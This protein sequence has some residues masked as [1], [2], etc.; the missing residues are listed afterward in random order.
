M[1]DK[2]QFKGYTGLCYYNCV[3]TKN[4]R[5][6]LK[7]EECTNKII[8]YQKVGNKYNIIFNNGKQYTYAGYNVKIIESELKDQKA[9]NCFEYLKDIANAI[10]LTKNGENILLSNYNKIDFI[11]SNS[12]LA[13]FI[14]QK[15]PNNDDKLKQNIVY[16]FGF[17]N[18]Q[19]LA[20]N[21]AL[22]N[23]LSIIQGP[24]GTGKTQTIL[25]II[26]N[27][28]MSG[29][30]V[31]VVSS[32]NSATKNVLDKLKKYDVDFIAAFLGNL[33]NRQEFIKSQSEIPDIS[34]WRIEPELFAELDNKLN[35]DYKELQEKLD[36]QN[37]LALLRQELSNVEL[38]QK[39]FIEYY[40]TLEVK[41]EPKCIRT[42]NSSLKTLD[43][44]FACDNYEEI[45]NDNSLIKFILI[46][47]EYLKL[48]DRKRLTLHNLIRK[49][50]YTLDFLKAQF[51]HKFYELKIEELKTDIK[52]LNNN[53][54]N[55]DFA[56]KMKA[57]SELSAR[58]FKH[59]LNKKYNTLAREP[60]KLEDLKRKANMFIEDY[61]VVLST[62][63]SLK[64]C[65]SNDVMYDYVIIDEASQ[66]DLCTGALAL[67]CARKA[68]VVGDLKQL[69]NVVNK[70]TA[71]LTDNIFRQYQLNEAYRYKNHCLLSSI[72]ELFKNAPKTLLKE[73]YRCHPKIIEFC[74]RKFYN[75]ELIILS[76]VKSDRTPLVLCYTTEGNHARNHYNQRQIDMIV[77][78]IIP[79]Y[80]ICLEDNSLGIVT[81]YRNQT[82]ALQKVF[83]G[84]TVK[85]DTVDKFQGQENKVIIIST[86]D[87][88]ISDFTDNPNR[89]NVAISR[90]I[91]QL[92]LVIN[93]DEISQD[94]NISDLINYIKYNNIEVYDSKLYSIFDYIYKCY[95]Q[96][97]KELLRKH[98]KISK[99]DSENL[100]Y[101]F[102]NKILNQ[103]YKK[104]FDIAAH[105]QLRT[106]IKDLSLLTSDREKQY[107]LNDLTHIDF[108]IYKTMDNSP[109]L[110]IEVDGYEYHKEWTK[111]AERDQL[112][113]EI[114]QKYG[115]PL[116]R[117]KTNGSNEKEILIKTIN[118]MIS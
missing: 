76:D 53:L 25:N 70:E 3:M 56:S 34:N 8:R 64:N 98:K 58:I 59:A 4:F 33:E 39:H 19:A 88:Q 60:Y 92:I 86:V 82:I 46:I 20:V 31:A 54:L 49:N 26:A 7:G 66:V 106:I 61:P 13:K 21:R 111:Q 97:K 67:A 114:L 29:Q 81:P 32:N 40:K 37:K 77:N 35:M 48:W 79:K 108:V 65:L 83:R 110:A 78:E 10:G 2:S 117:F 99:Y 96:R 57:Y 116:L 71:Q 52:K 36:V 113:D 75:N 51:Q 107:L 102:I 17:N 115:I 47:L 6:F 84:T 105:V 1:Y 43:M 94:K 38:E 55:Y 72:S 14:S 18:S 89:L 12:M 11:D 100:M 101:I 45:T 30:S 16:P 109:F 15:H 103:Y 68:V 95:E 91:E 85:A 73:H 104:Q 74:N 118:D 87:N 27:I 5:I 44:I 69:P 23:E 62:T 90:A 63:Y 9:K 28:I 112:K 50:K 24:P 22:S 80:N 41:P 93:S 42:V